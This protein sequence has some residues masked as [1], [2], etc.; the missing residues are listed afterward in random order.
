[1][2]LVNARKNVEKRLDE[3]KL[4]PS[5]K[6]E[7]LKQYIIQETKR[8]DGDTPWTDYELNGG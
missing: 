6:W 8:I 7:N 3:S 1:M 2:C 4:T 5:E